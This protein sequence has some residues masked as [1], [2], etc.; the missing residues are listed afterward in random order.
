MWFSCAPPR[1]T[2]QT[3]P[4]VLV[5]VLLSKYMWHVK[6]M[7][8]IVLSSYLRISCSPKNPDSSTRHSGIHLYIPFAC[9]WLRTKFVDER[10]NSLAPYSMSNSFKSYYSGKTILYC[11]NYSQN[12]NHS[13]KLLSSRPKCSAHHTNNPLLNTG[14]ELSNRT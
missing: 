6:K 3:S 9:F 2:N 5:L 7:N 13:N 14:Q 11:V 12:A 1:C 8:M 10:C 4:H